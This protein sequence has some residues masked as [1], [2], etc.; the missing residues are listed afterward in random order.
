MRGTNRDQSR[1]CSLM[2]KLSIRAKS[3]NHKIHIQTQL[4]FTYSNAHGKHFK[5]KI[6]HF[7][8][9]LSEILAKAKPGLIEVRVRKS[10]WNGASGCYQM[11]FR[12]A[13]AG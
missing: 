12:G 10:Q 3:T 8:L 13:V 6:K 2:E 11:Y 9:R 5:I 4:C 7:Q 1:Y